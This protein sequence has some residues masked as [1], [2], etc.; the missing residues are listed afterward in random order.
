MTADAGRLKERFNILGV[1]EAGGLGGRRQFACVHL[2]DIPF[3]AGHERS[4]KARQCD[5]NQRGFGHKVG[6]DC[7]GVFIISKETSS[8]SRSSLEA[9]S[10]GV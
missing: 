4:A 2:C 8:S 5:K 3:V 9:F 1:R 10:V 6:S 7:A